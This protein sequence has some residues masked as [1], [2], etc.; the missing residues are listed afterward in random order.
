[1]PLDTVKTKMQLKSFASP[2]ACVRSIVAADGVGGLYY[3]FQPFL[4]QAS[5]K[6][7]VRFFFYENIITAVDLMGID[8]SSSPARWSML[9]GLGAGM[10]EA[11][12]WTAPTERLKVLRQASAGLGQS[13]GAGRHTLL[14]LFREQ[15]I[16]GLYVGAGPT[17]ARQA[18]STAVRFAVL[19][20]LRQLACSTC[21]YDRKS[22]PSWV[23]FLAGGTAGA[24]SAVANNPIDVV[25]SR[26]QSG[27]AD[28]GILS[29]IKDLLREDGIRAFGAGLQ[30]R[31]VRLFLSQAIQFTI[32]DAL[33]NTAR[34]KQLE[35]GGAAS[36][37]G[38]REGDGFG[39]GAHIR[40]T[41]TKKL[42]VVP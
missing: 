38:G 36:S 25:K 12:L 17:A 33:V 5:G 22:I 20:H 41:G 21:G 2:A 30:A 35:N 40:R 10:G 34:P 3:G 24:V 6:A 14:T 37:S 7:A 18:S 29:C 42:A 31:C 15:G 39:G 8:R 26:I 32:V 4:I 23:T 27:V 11:L 19:E 1:M 16:G 13:A 9:C 28:R